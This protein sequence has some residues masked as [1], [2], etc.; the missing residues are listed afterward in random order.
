[1]GTIPYL[2]IFLTDLVM[3]DNAMKDYL[4]ERVIN[5]E[6]M[7]KEF[8]VINQIK[9]LQATYYKY[10]ISPQELFRGWFWDMDHLSVAQR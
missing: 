1:M 10:N 3:L 6:K 5:V 8:H 9:Q 4:N 2:G 7:R